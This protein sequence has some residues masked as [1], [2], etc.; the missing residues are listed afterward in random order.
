[1]KK[2]YIISRCISKKN[3]YYDFHFKGFY[4]GERVSVV[5]L[6]TNSGFIEGESYLIELV[7]PTIKNQVLY[8]RIKRKK[9]L[10]D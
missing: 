4:H 1:M 3:E 5:R 10:F 9:V 6:R 8:G 2:L 7:E